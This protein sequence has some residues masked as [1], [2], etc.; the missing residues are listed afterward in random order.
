MLLRLLTLTV[1]QSLDLVTF[2]L[3]VGRRGV[4]AESN[5]LVGSMFTA[6]G[7]AAV[8]TLKV[9]LILLIGALTV[10]AWARGA[11]GVWALVGA[12]PLGLAIVAGILGGWTNAMAYLG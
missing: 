2:W 11:R 9:L 1:A 4:V 6:H 7:M 3:M 5:P 12:I 8:A 10:A